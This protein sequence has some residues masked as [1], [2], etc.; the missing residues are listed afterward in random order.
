MCGRGCHTFI[1]HCALM[2][3]GYGLIQTNSKYNFNST[4]KNILSIKLN[5][6]FSKFWKNATVLQ[7]AQKGKISEFHIFLQMSAIP[8]PPPWK[9]FFV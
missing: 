9:Y 2:G 1:V 6:L 4:E 7:M 8:P 3:L 5:L